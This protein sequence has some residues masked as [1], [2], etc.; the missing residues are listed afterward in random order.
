[1]SELLASEKRT[2]QR[3][4]AIEDTLE[5]IKARLINPSG[6]TTSTARPGGATI[7][8][9]AP[10]YSPSPIRSVVLSEPTLLPTLRERPEPSSSS[11]EVRLGH[12]GTLTVHVRSA[13]GLIKADFYGLSDPYA[14][15]HVSALDER[16]TST[17]KQTLDP[18]W[19]EKVDF[20]G[21]LRD[22]VTQELV[23]EVF[24]EDFGW[25]GGLK[26]QLGRSATSKSTMNRN[27]SGEPGSSDSNHSFKRKGDDK[28]GRII[29]LSLEFLATEDSKEFNDVELQGVKSG[30]ISFTVIWE[31][32]SDDDNQVKA[33]VER[34]PEIRALLKDVRKQLEYASQR[35]PFPAPR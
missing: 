21:P 29:P 22:F 32:T 7:S 13:S 18:R 12:L 10:S 3:L 5:V 11:E 9:A 20:D 6:A 1:M 24:D 27:S 8:T 34:D 14:I 2:E 25:L 4:G 17:K 16:R 19:D 23:I 33:L 15:V 30:T 35:H 31:P 28:L 26:P